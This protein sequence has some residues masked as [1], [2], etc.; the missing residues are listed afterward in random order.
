MRDSVPLSL[1][2]TD[3]RTTR[4]QAY[5]A[6]RRGILGGALEAG[7]RLVQSEIAE[8][9]G[10]S[11]TPV[12]EALR[13]L[14]AEGLVRFD[15]YR[16]AVVQRPNMA[17]IREIYNLRIVLEPVAIRQN[18]ENLTDKE[19]IRATELQ[20]LMDEERDLGVWVELNNQFHAVFDGSTSPRM[21]AILRNLRD[22]AALVVGFSNRVRPTLIDASNRQHHL[23]LKACRERDGDAAA[24]IV[25]EHVRETLEAME[26][27]FADAN[28]P[29]S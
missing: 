13:D 29:Q 4:E 25:E 10:V 7:T 23:L 1:L 8:A 22:S 3:R 28:D 21:N 19:L 11:T 18:V 5:E 9:L 16:G 17:E 2:E 14:A 6:L 26:R 27:Y 24:K 15:D 12:R 20:D